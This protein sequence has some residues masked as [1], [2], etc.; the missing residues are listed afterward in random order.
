MDEASQ[1]ASTL[2]TPMEVMEGVVPQ[3]MVRGRGVAV[4]TSDS[5]WCA[6]VPYA[7]T[8]RT[9]ILQLVDAHQNGLLVEFV[10][11]THSL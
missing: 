3:V 2:V 10:L 7:E 6:A 4:T 8:V 11:D 1:K 9:L 5:R